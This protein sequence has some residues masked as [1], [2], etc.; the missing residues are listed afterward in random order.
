MAGVETMRNFL[1]KLHKR[2]RKK[3]QK[4]VRAPHLKEQKGV[5]SPHLTKQPREKL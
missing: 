2:S 5:R 1:E 3:E 4:G